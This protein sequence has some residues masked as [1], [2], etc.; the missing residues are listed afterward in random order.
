MLLEVAILLRARQKVFTLAEA[1][2]PFNF[3][4]KGGD[5]YG[6]SLCYID[7]HYCTKQYN[8]DIQSG[9]NHNEKATPISQIVWLLNP[10]I[11]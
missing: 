9:E 4:T 10:S 11:L 5:S 3:K 2:T 6:D 8:C 1:F 7:D